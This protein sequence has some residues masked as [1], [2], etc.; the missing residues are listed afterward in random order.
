MTK[1]K[2]VEEH[3]STRCTITMDEPAE[4]DKES[5]IISGLHVTIEPTVTITKEQLINLVGAAFAY[6]TADPDGFCPLC[7][8]MIDD[9]DLNCE[10][11]ELRRLSE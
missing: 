3:G 9:H 10:L 5:R 2:S 8:G 11:E 1:R 7:N 6:G 4:G